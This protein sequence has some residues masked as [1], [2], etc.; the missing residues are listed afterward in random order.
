MTS[1]C[2]PYHIDNVERKASKL[3]SGLSNL[4]YEERLIKAHFTNT[5]ILKT[6]EI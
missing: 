2:C 4:S 6:E 5:T 1:V 3:V